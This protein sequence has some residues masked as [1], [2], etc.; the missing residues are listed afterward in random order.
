M[1]LQH[2]KA[3]VF[4]WAGTVVD[5]GSF[6]PMGVF[7]EVFGEFGV[8]ISVDEARIPMGM[9]KRPHIAAILALPRVA[10]AWKEARGGDP[11]EADIDALYEI[12]VPRNRAVAAKHA[13][14][15]PGVAEA[16]AACRDLGL[17]IGS[18][19]GYTRDIMAEIMPVAAKQ[20]FAPDSLVCT[21]DT[22][23]GRPTPL[24]MYRTFVELGVHPAWSVVKVDDTEVGIGEGIDAGSWAVG[25]SVT[26]NLF[27][28]T[29]AE[30]KELDAAEF[31]QRRQ[32]AADKLSAAGAHFVIDGVADLL[33]VLH[34]IEGRLARGERP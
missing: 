12:F 1:P 11:T 25:I 13:D 16:V 3:V 8:A 19:T 29:E 17:R 9:A 7:V 14:V 28:M 27:G 6:A 23:E 22:S 2:L 21:G 4:D 31:A 34:V 32:R 5:Y 10:A 20:G 18:T 15:I 30:T 26:G 33:P 24:M